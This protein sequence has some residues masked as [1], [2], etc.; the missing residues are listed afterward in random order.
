MSKEYRSLSSSL[1]NLLYSPVTSSL[2][3]PN[4]L[5]NTLFSNTLSLRSSL[6]ARDQVSHPYR[7]PLHLQST[8]T[9]SQKQVHESFV[10]NMRADGRERRE[11]L[12]QDVTSS[13]ACKTTNCLFCHT[14]GAWSMSFLEGFTALLWPWG[15][16][17]G[18]PVTGG[19]IARFHY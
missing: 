15:S 12:K 3:G 10:C 8:K 14:D 2:L 5:L 16:K 18:D 19:L 4:T 11:P 9:F 17:P 6:S 7:T 13:C 1:C